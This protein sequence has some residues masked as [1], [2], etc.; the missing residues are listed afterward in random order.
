MN[1]ATWIYD[2]LTADTTIIGKVGTRVYRDSAPKGTAFPFIAY[3]LV[4]SV[5]VSNAFKDTLMTSERWQIKVVDKGNAYSNIDVV[6]PQIISLLH[7]QSSSGVVSS[8]L[9]S[10]FQ[11][12]EVDDGV[13][14]KTGLIEFR[15]HT[16]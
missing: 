1:S 4:G 14:Y 12:S 16:Q 10:Y 7:K 15:V 2:T 5:P 8:T 3:Q 11:I 13:T 9:E 6:A